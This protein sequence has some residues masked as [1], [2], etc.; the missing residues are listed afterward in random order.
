ML[1]KILLFLLKAYHY[2]LS[3]VIG[4]T[5]RF[6]PS[7]SQ[8]MYEALSQHGFWLGTFLGTKRVLR[9]FPWCKGGVDPVPKTF[10]FFK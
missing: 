6:Y 2:L 8:Y 1:I 5:C 3:P 10:H 7:C 9:C 4:Q